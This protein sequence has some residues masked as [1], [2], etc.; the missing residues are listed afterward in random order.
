MISTSSTDSTL[1]PRYNGKYLTLGSDEYL[2]VGSTP[3]AWLWTGSDLNNQIDSEGYYYLS[4][5]SSS[6][7]FTTSKNTN[8]TIVMYEQVMQGTSYYCT[9]PVA[10]TTYYTVTFKNWD[11]TVLKTEQVE[12]GAS[13][14]APAVPARTGYTF[15]GWDVDFTNVMSDLVVTAQFTVNSYTLT[16]NYLNEEDEVI[17]PAYTAQVA[18]GANFSVESPVIAGYTTTQTVVTGTMPASDYTV[19]VYYEAEPIVE[20]NLLGDVDCNGTVDMSDISMLFSYL[21]GTT[22]L[23]EQGLANANAN[24]DDTV[25]VMDITAIFNIIANS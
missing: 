5:S 20:P 8:G 15:T 16:I 2:I 3:L 1:I 17:A 4:R 9:D 6:A 10:Q 25:N 19:N 22:E 13:A 12:E 18:Y 7:Y 21:N 23:T 14:T 11:G 24:G